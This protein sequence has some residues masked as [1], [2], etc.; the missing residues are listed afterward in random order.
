MFDREDFSLYSR[1]SGLDPAGKEDLGIIKMQSPRYRVWLKSI[2]A[3]VAGV[4]LFQQ[5]AWAGDLRDLFREEDS[6]LQTIE[7]WEDAMERQRELVLDREP[8]ALGEGDDASADPGSERRAEDL[9]PVTSVTREGV[10]QVNVHFAEPEVRE[11][12]GGYSRVVLSGVPAIGVPGEPLLPA[13]NFNLLLPYNCDIEDIRLLLGAKSEI[14]N[15]FRSLPVQPAR[16]PGAISQPGDKIPQNDGIY[17][18]DTVFPGKKATVVTVQ[19]KKGYRIAVLRVNPFEYIPS[20]GTLSYY[21]DMALRISLKDEMI[22]EDII[23]SGDRLAPRQDADDIAEIKRMVINPEDI[24]SYAA[25]ATTASPAGEGRKEA[26]AATMDD[27]R[28]ED[29]KGDEVEGEDDLEKDVVKPYSA[30]EKG[31]KPPEDNETRNRLLTEIRQRA[32]LLVKIENTI[33]SYYKRFLNRVK[34]NTDGSGIAILGENGARLIDTDDPALL[35]YTEYILKLGLPYPLPKCPGSV[36]DLE[37]PAYYEIFLD[38]GMLHEKKG[39]RLI[40]VQVSKDMTLERM[41]AELIR[42][43]DT[44]IPRE[45]ESLLRARKVSSFYLTESIRC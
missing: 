17:Y 45:R 7:Q 44:L 22:S 11:V 41:K 6:P 20:E 23:A 2:A 31:P 8:V 16:L 25:Y 33:E 19:N 29:E 12:E 38:E 1:E 36:V 32:D 4:F 9:E 10:I 15:D 34:V 27:G 24:D 43:G 5:I 14:E 39:P 37:L 26:P 28:A 42:L 3:V 13:K 30:Q 18:S 35:Y 21:K 40:R